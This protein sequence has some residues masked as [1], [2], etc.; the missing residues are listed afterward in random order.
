MRAPS[1]NG[2]LVRSNTSPAAL[3]PSRPSFAPGPENGYHA[4]LMQPGP[5]IPI[6]GYESNERSA[7]GTPK[8]KKTPDLKYI[9]KLAQAQVATDLHA[10]SF[11]P[12]Q[13]Q[14]SLSP[15]TDIY[16]ASPLYQRPSFSEPRQIVSKYS[17]QTTSSAGSAT[18]QS[19][20]SNSSSVSTTSTPNTS[21]PQPT[22]IKPPSRTPSPQAQSTPKALPVPMSKFTAPPQTHKTRGR[23][24]TTSTG[25][26]SPR[27]TAPLSQL[28]RP[29]LPSISGPTNLSS[30]SPSTSTTPNS[31]SPRPVVD[32]KAER[33]ETH[34]SEAKANEQDDNEAR[35][36]SLADVSI[37]RQ[38]SVSRQ[39]RQLLVP[40][41][42]SNSMR[43]KPSVISPPPS[44]A[45]S[46]ENPSI[47]QNNPTRPTMRARA[48]TVSSSSPSAPLKLYN[49]NFP[50]PL[51]NL[52]GAGI[53]VS[54]VTSP[55][56]AVEKATREEWEQQNSIL[57]SVSGSGSGRK[58]ERERLVSGVKPNTPTLVIV[59][60]NGSS[61]EEEGVRLKNWDGS[62][63]E[64][65]KSDGIAER[66]RRAR[67]ERD[68]R[69]HEYRKSEK[70]V[71]ER[72]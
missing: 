69:G 60:G 12:D 61:R 71:V 20:H 41:R 54:R 17:T 22:T 70:V 15:E 5:H 10:R 28:P 51:H 3:S 65:K 68:G 55:L 14:L 7:S 62:V 26:P 29:R 42:G 2:R 59:G 30:T 11:T 57:V 21:N 49:Q 64:R 23:S 58:K 32:T 31:S 43:G 52:Q 18:S 39:Q 66:R 16:D 53:N 63:L 27:A 56:S 47:A 4:T 67:Q 36:K 40:I 34:Q 13:Q 48:S 1:P 19:D 72:V 37:A 35:L 46:G 38:I 6:P 8:P 24:A 44:K 9:V 33:D 25:T 45:A 50:S